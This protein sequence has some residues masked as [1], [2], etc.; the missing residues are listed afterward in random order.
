MRYFVNSPVDMALTD[1]FSKLIKD[2]V[3]AAHTDKK[4]DDDIMG[5]FHE[6]VSCI[7]PNGVFWMPGKNLQLE[8]LFARELYYKDIS[9]YLLED[10]IR[11]HYGNRYVAQVAT[12]A[13]QSDLRS[14]QVSGS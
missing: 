14:S 11:F 7:G 5:M 3:E 4:R 10:S 6:I 9:R 12:L 13:A 8:Q 1:S 2:Y